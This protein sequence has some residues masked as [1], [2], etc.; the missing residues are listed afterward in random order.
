MS[1]SITTWTAMPSRYSSPIRMSSTAPRRNRRQPI[2]IS[3]D[4]TITA[5]PTPAAA[6]PSDRRSAAVIT[7]AT[8]VGTGPKTRPA[9][10]SRTDRV[11]NTIPGV[12]TQGVRMITMPIVPSR[13]PISSWPSLPRR[14][15]QR[16][17]ATS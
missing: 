14:T 16:V 11:S 12:S 6:P 3:P 17:V 15:V 13:T 7:M 2:P 5:T 9:T 10:A 8:S 4:A 1:A